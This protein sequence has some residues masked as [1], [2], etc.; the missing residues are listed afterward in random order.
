M[1]VRLSSHVSLIYS[2]CLHNSSYRILN[3]QPLGK[4]MGYRCKWALSQVW[5]QWRWQEREMSCWTKHWAYVVLSAEVAELQVPKA[6]LYLFL[7]SGLHTWL[8]CAK[9]NNSCL[10]WSIIFQLRDLWIKDCQHRPEEG[11]LKSAWIHW[12]CNIKWHTKSLN[13]CSPT[14]ILQSLQHPQTNAC[15]VRK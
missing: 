1:W 4:L 5:I 13:S 9:S 12:N 14:Y 15:P 2:W 10:T 7:S 11:S 6:E 3:D 8:L